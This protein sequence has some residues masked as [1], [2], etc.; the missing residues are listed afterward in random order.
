[1]KL[2]RF[3][4][5]SSPGEIR[6]GLVYSGKIY[7]TDGEQS[8]A[9]HEA[10]QVRPLSP[11]GRPPSIRIFRM[12]EGQLPKT[13][14]DGVPLY[15]HTNPSGLYGPSQIV[16]KPATVAHLDF[17]T[18][19]IAIVGSDGLQIPV[20]NGDSYI[21]GFTL[22]IQLVSRDLLREEAEQAS[23]IGRSFDIG[24]VIGPVIS[25][26]DDLDEVVT[27]EIP[28]RKYGLS[29]VTRL[30]GVEHGRGEIADLPVSFAELVAAASDVGPV[31]SGDLLAIG[32][33]ASGDGSTFLESGDDVQV[34]VEHLGT[35]SLKVG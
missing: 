19:L 25:T 20:E 9:V 1:M 3:E 22:A 12:S 17:E 32:P 30:N 23:G 5:K 31:R 35:L 24:G 2:C 27:E 26:P 10:D 11:V 21:L 34:S 6:S 13:D 7:E 16:P 14:D 18:Y 28:A 4:L 8:I 29:V 15:F 33:I